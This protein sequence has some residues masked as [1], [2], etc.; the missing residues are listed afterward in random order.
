MIEMEVEAI[1]IDDKTMLPVVILSDD[2]GRRYL[3]IRMGIYEAEAICL[4]LAGVGLPRPR[5]Y[6]LLETL[7][8]ESG[9]KV[10]RIVL[11]DVSEKI[12]CAKICIENRALNFELD[13]IKVF[14]LAVVTTIL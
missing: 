11:D 8:I 2:K 14:L 12:L 1:E 10:D 4:E 5:V 7:I 3:A 13:T 6:D 9:M